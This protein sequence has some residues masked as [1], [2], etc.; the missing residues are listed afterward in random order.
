MKIKL[1]RSATIGIFGDSF[2]LLTDPWLV[3]GEYYGS[4]SH[5]PEFNFEKYK[6]EIDSFDAMYISHIH[7]DH[8][9]SLTLNKINKNIPVYIST[10]HSKFLKKNLERMGF[11]V[12]ELEN[13]KRKKL[14]NN[15][16]ITIYPAD[17]CDPELCYKFYGCGKPNLVS[18]ES[19]LNFTPT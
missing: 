7:P 8:C 18:E 4:W 1:Y 3:D 6:D 13:G 15:F 16:F 17:N 11:K 5:Y 19:L 2:K 9:S 12:F 14:S 10:Y